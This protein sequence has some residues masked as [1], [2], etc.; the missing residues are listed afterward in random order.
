MTPRVPGTLRRLHFMDR[1]RGHAVV[2]GLVLGVE[3]IGFIL[4][5]FFGE[6]RPGVAVPVKCH[7]TFVTRG[8]RNLVLFITA[9]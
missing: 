4:D 9:I 7:V 2:Q 3:T 5:A 6:R 8:A 1:H